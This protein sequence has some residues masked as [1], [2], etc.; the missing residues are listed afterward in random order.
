MHGDTRLV[1]PVDGCQ[2]RAAVDSG[3]RAGVA[4]REHIDHAVA[5]CERLDQLQ[6][7][8]AD[9]AIVFDVVLADRRSTGVGRL[10][11]LLPL[12]LLRRVSYLAQRPAQ[13]DRCGPRLEQH[14]QVALQ[15]CV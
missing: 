11:A 13:I 2:C 14:L 3:Q 12:M 7:V 10:D 4:V 1:R 15:G 8:A 6:S 9:G 5:A